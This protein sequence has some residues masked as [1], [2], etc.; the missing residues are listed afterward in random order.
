MPRIYRRNAREDYLGLAKCRK[1]VGKKL[2]NAVKKQLQYVR[3]N[4]GYVDAFLEE[5]DVRI[6][7]RQRHRQNLG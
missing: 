1:R 7:A 5:E 3:R 2:R 4:L 6:G